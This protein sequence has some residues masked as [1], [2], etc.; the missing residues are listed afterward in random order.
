M[1]PLPSNQLNEE[2]QS[3]ASLILMIKSGIDL[4]LSTRLVSHTQY[5]QVKSLSLVVV[6]VAPKKQL[7]ITPLKNANPPGKCTTSLEHRDVVADPV[8]LVLRNAL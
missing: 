6:V 8:L 1:T 7:N 3:H 4:K 5:N 2:T